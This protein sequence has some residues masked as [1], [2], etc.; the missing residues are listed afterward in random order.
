MHNPSTPQAMQSR[1]VFG[2]TAITALTAQNSH[3]VQ[4]VMPVA[5]DF[6][7]VQMDSVLSGENVRTWTWSVV[8]CM[9]RFTV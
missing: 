3:G 5:L 7:E 2:M 1:G 4:A 6:I 8:G 9:H